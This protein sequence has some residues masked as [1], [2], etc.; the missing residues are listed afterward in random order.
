MLSDPDFRGGADL[1]LLGWWQSGGSDRRDVSARAHEAGTSGFSQLFWPAGISCGAV[2][3]MADGGAGGGCGVASG[4]DG[5]ASAARGEVSEDGAFASNGLGSVP[6]MK[7]S[8]NA[9]FSSRGVRW[10]VM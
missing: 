8:K 4:G 3:E 9:P 10:P 1:T 2:G 7:Y 6:L 5:E